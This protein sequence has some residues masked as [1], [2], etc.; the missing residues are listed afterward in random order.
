MSEISD[1]SIIECDT[2]LL[3][4]VVFIAGYTTHKYLKHSHCHIYQDLLTI[5]KD[6][7]IDDTSNPQFKVIE[8]SDREGLKYPSQIVMDSI[9][10][11]WKN[12][13]TSK[14]EHKSELM[15]VF[16]KGPS[17]KII[18]DLTHN[19][20]ENTEGFEIWRNSCASCRVCGWSIVRRLVF[21]ASNCL[22]ANKV[23]DYNSIV[24]SKGI[25]KR[26]LKKFNSK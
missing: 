4:S 6:L 18:V 14:I 17:R 8:L 26:K 24:V 20:L 12:L 22:I 23:K 25:E 13:L 1:L 21:V 7:L 5:D 10:V 2:Q 3:Q 9:I 16:L 11:V 19:Y 15:S